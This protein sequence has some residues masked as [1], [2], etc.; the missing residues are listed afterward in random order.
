MTE[1]WEKGKK[2]NNPFSERAGYTAWL[3]E[4][5]AAANQNVES[6]MPTLQYLI[7][8]WSSSFIVQGSLSESHLVAQWLSEAATDLLLKKAHFSTVD[9]PLHW[10]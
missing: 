7:L 8:T 1:T 4:R 2:Q 10:F 6:W 3:L 5:Y 9:E